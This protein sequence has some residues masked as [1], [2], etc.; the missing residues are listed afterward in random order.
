MLGS[1]PPGLG[2]GWH[3]DSSEAS[4]RPKELPPLSALLP[5]QREGIL[6]SGPGQQPSTASSSKLTSPRSE[7]QF[8]SKPRFHL[9]TLPPK[10]SVS[11]AETTADQLLKPHAPCLVSA[12]S[13]GT[14]RSP[15]RLLPPPLPSL[16][17]SLQ[18]HLTDEDK[19]SE[20]LANL[21]E[22]THLGHSRDKS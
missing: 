8:C 3:H 22:V 10:P 20:M 17:R 4:G 1:T 7:P 21:P 11:R 16:L 13:S 5:L 6:S 19:G 12:H 14:P 18:V 2:E 9:P 15:L